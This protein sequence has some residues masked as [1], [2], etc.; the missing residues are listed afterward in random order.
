MRC[1]IKKAY[2]HCVIV[3][4][5]VLMIAVLSGCSQKIDGEKTVLEKSVSQAFIAD[6]LTFVASNR[7]SVEH[8]LTINTAALPA[9]SKIGGDET[10]VKVELID[11][12]QEIKD[13]QKL[14]IATLSSRNAQAEV[15]LGEPVTFTIRSNK[16]TA[17]GPHQLKVALD[18]VVDDVTLSSAMV[19][20]EPDK[21]RYSSSDDYE[22]YPLLISTSQ[23]GNYAIGS[24]DHDVY[25]YDQS[26]NIWDDVTL[27]LDS[28]DNFIVESHKISPDGQS[29]M[30]VTS[31]P[32][33]GESDN[34]NVYMSRD[35]GKTWHVTTIYRDYSSGD[36]H[37]DGAVMS[38][39]GKYI[40]LAFNDFFNGDDTIYLSSDYGMSFKS[41]KLQMPSTK[42]YAFYVDMSDDGRI[43]LVS[44]GVISPGAIVG[45]DLGQPAQHYVYLSTNYGKDWKSINHRLT[46]ID[47]N[48]SS[49]PLGYSLTMSLVS[50]DADVLL[51]GGA[52]MV[53]EFTTDDP[54]Y[55]SFA[56]RSLDQGMTWEVINDL[57]DIDY[58]YFDTR[59]VA[60][61]DDGSKIYVGFASDDDHKVPDPLLYY[62]GDSGH[63]FKPMSLGVGNDFHSVQFINTSSSADVTLFTVNEYADKTSHPACKVVADQSVTNSDG[64]DV[65]YIYAFG[66]LYS[67]VFPKFTVTATALS[68]DGRYPVLGIKNENEMATFQQ[69]N[70]D[71]FL[72]VA[73]VGVACPAFYRSW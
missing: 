66:H 18:G 15:K 57:S 4:I 63:T 9:I 6:D 3:L 43:M 65:V 39:D 59:R 14:R 49:L 54:Y 12:R 61:S 41:F 1:G 31:V 52:R 72:N 50:N 60:M 2:H 62:S 13:V 42:V 21:Y 37:G 47:G 28:D 53:G 58:A 26:R 70:L 55:K 22:T 71:C 68:K 27:D 24:T 29:V 8:H 56:Y 69:V 23:D 7:S 11:A 30:V 17:I 35:Y 5:T 16:E 10:Y 44:S 64:C 46:S 73:P 19:V 45:D 40:M 48:G 38:A 36:L 33:E 20:K 67:A 34:V 25:I 51:L 32:K